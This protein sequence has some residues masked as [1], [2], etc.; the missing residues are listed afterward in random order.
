MLP[1]SSGLNYK[2]RVQIG[3]LIYRGTAGIGSPGGPTEVGTTARTS[4]DLE[5]LFCKSREIRE[6]V[7]PIEQWEVHGGH[8]WRSKETVAPE[9]LFQLQSEKG[10]LSQPSL[11]IYVYQHNFSR[12]SC[13]SYNLK[14][15][16]A[17]SSEMLVSLHQTTRRLIQE[18]SNLHTERRENLKPSHAVFLSAAVSSSAQLSDRAPRLITLSVFNHA[19]RLAKLYKIRYETIYKWWT[20][21]DVEGSGINI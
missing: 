11:S 8:E 18:N 19:F 3:T 20:G 4:M 17:H 21:K 1:P 5:G 7:A 12:L 15:E 13:Y 14:M 6:I 9:G 2:P 10:P 16:G